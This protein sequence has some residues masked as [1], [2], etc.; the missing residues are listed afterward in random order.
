MNSTGYYQF[1]TTNVTT[2]KISVLKVV[3]Y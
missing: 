2:G 3:R 1:T